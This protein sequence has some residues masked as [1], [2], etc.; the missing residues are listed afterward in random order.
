MKTKDGKSRPA[1]NGRAKTRRTFASETVYLAVLIAFAAGFLAGTV[2]TVYRT[3]RLPAMAGPGGP[4]PGAPDPLI[5]GH[6]R[7][8]HSTG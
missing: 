2:F 4:S 6:V 1:T 5:S 3:T 7:Y 8:G